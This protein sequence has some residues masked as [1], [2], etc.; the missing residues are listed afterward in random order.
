M[1]PFATAAKAKVAT[2]GVDAM[3]GRLHEF[4]KFRNEKFF[5][6]FEDLGFDGISDGSRSL[7]KDG[8]AI[9]ESAK[10]LILIP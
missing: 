8:Y 6:N 7:H 2:D 10:A 1:L 9:F 4:N 3:G 5:L